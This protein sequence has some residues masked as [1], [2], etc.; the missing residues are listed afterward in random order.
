MIG[1]RLHKLA[2]AIAEHE[3]WDPQYKVDGKDIIGTLA[4]RNHNPG[5]LR[6]SPFQV[7]TRNGFA[8]FYN[9][10]VGRFALIYDLWVKA[11]GKSSTGL[12]ASSTIKDFVYK[13]APPHE[14]DSE[15]YLAFILSRTGFSAD[16]PLS[17]LLL[18]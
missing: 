9:D 13:Y 6:L 4:Y 8:V 12:T 7:Y 3:G 14:N 1:S 18:K 5:N 2:Q 11:S 17:D 15:A 16:M 10:E